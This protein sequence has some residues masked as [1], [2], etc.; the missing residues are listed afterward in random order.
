MSNPMKNFALDLVKLAR[1]LT[2]PK[3]IPQKVANS[4]EFEMGSL[5]VPG[6]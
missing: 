2:R 4:R 3:I 6:W 5:S 1:D